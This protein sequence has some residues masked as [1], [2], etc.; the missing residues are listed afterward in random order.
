MLSR[1]LSVGTLNDYIQQVLSA[2]DILA[3][4]WVEGEVTSITYA[5]SGHAYFK[6]ADDGALIDGVMWRSH[7]ARQM[8]RPQVGDAIILHGR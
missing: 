4:L 1:V 2:D 7:L 3:D 5:R 6:L 8:V